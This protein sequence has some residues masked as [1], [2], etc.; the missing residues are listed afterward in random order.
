MRR[1]A[2]IISAL[3]LLLSAFGATAQALPNRPFTVREEIGLTDFAIVG[4][5]PYPI[6]VSPNGRFVAVWSERGLLKEDRVED[7]LRVYDEGQLRKFLRHSRQVRPPAPVLDLREATFNEGPIISQVRWLP[8]SKGLAFLLRSAHDNNELMVISLQQSRPRALSL[9]EQDVTAFDVRDASH[10][11]YAVASLG[12]VLPAQ[13][14]SGGVAWDISGQFLEDILLR[15]E[16]R[17]KLIDIGISYGGRLRSVLWAA[18]SDAPHVLLQGNGKPI[19]IYPPQGGMLAL[20]PDGQTVAAALPV[21]TVPA[22]WVREFRP[23][24]AG[25]P[26]NMLRAGRQKLDL[27]V[28]DMFTPTEYVL[29]HVRNGAITPVNSEPT[30]TVLGWWT[31]AGPVWSDDGRSLLLPDVYAHPLGGHN[32]DASPCVGIFYPATGELRCLKSLRL[33]AMPVRRGTPEK[34]GFLVIRSLEFAGR[35]SGR[36]VIQYYGLTN[37]QGY[38]G[39]AKEVLVHRRN[40]WLSAGA[41]EVPR[42]QQTLES[43]QTALDVHIEQGLNESP[44]L[45]ARDR[46]TGVSRTIWDPNPNLEH[47]RLGEAMVYHWTDMNGRIWSA[48]LYKPAHYV[49][50]ERY[51]LVIQTH[52]F[53]KDSFRPSGF[54]PTAFAARA[55][56]ASGI[57][58][59]QVPECLHIQDPAFGPCEVAMYESAVTHLAKEGLIDPNRVGII[60]FSQTVFTVLEALT[61]SQ[62]R[63]A[64]ASITD[65]PTFGYWEYLSNVD[66]TDSRNSNAADATIGAEPFGAGLRLWQD[67]SPVFRMENVHTP[68]I[69]NSL[70][71]GSLLGGMWEPYATLRYLHKPVDVILLR[72]DEHVLT[73]PAVR[74]ASQGGSV[75]WFRFWLQGY[76]SSSPVMAGEYLRWE[77]LCDLQRREN[78]DRPTWCIPAE[79]HHAG[80]QGSADP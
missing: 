35:D 51:P 79:R 5:I 26:Y 36:V 72:S 2:L 70:G 73:N 71:R 20:S 47:T 65:G 58:V 61:S 56:A 15:K 39:N 28:G 25:D 68:L 54:A 9:R 43:Q 42:G 37:T 74:L 46:R 31:V 32:L 23:P 24:F 75:D 10:Y 40:G 80:F 14:K 27:T 21:A 45:V 50:G 6:M 63:F 49:T 22:H 77:R 48:G 7:D 16:L 69:V 41:A 4:S 59:L 57:V 62:I 1:S 33:G 60:G 3:A 18:A 55:L 38:V 34:A 8:T 29:I 12:R 30:G 44:V 53:L 66:S 76:E 67:R 11:V 78:S 17:R 64:A 19:V 13:S 52:G